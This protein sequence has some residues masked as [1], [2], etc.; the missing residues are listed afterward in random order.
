MCKPS[1]KVQG[2]DIEHIF[3][4]WWHTCCGCTTQLALELHQNIISRYQEALMVGWEIILHQTIEWKDWHWPFKLQPS[5]ALLVILA[6]ETSCLSLYVY[7]APM[8]VVQCIC[9]K[10][11]KEQHATDQPFQNQDA[12]KIQ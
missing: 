3:L 11:P 10:L 7:E 12:K 4:F 2:V 5:Y 9:S 1:V 8:L 6:T